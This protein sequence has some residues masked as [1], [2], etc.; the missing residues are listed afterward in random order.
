VRERWQVES[1]ENRWS[2]QFYEP[3]DGL[4]LI[5][6]SLSSSRVLVATGFSGTGMVFGT[7]G[8]MLMADLVLGRSN[9]WADL[10]KP[11]RFKPL[12]AGPHVAKLN[13]EVAATFV[14]DRLKVPSVDALSEV[15]IGEGKVVQ[16]AGKK[17]AVYREESGAVHAVS[18]VCTHAACIVHWN[19]AEKTWDCPCHGGRYQPDGKVLEGPP[20]KDLEPVA[21]EELTEAG[22]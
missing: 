7:L 13:L 20:V 22:R 9:P 3:P 19:G 17:V 6:E 15:P 5:G 10:Y 18:P 11:S 21:V 14:L 4:P 1:I 16:I 8:G 12:A 2:A